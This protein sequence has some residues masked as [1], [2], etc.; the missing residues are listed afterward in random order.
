[1]KLIKLLAIALMTVGFA[2]SVYAQD[3]YT[4]KE[5]Q[6]SFDETVTAVEKAIK[7]LESKGITLFNIINHG[8]NAKKAGGKM[9]KGVLFIFGNP[10]NGSPLMDQF[11]LT[12]IELPLKIYVYEDKGKVYAAY[13]N[14]VQTATFFKGSEKIKFV[15]V[16]QKMLDMITTKA[17]SK[18]ASK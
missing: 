18:A 14:T 1:M 5:S 6:K 7:G 4:V 16:S 10:K 17:T 8:E 11:P 12:G 9:G 2:S 13:I 3:R 15:E